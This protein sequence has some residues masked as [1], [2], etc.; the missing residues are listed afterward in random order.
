MP[1][2]TRQAMSK[3]KQ[4]SSEDSGNTLDEIKLKAEVKEIKSAVSELRA[5]VEYTQAEVDSIKV[6]LCNT[7]PNFLKLE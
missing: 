2:E 6:D 4:V 7:K 3:S 1:I 5:S